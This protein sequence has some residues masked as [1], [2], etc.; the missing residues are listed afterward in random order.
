MLHLVTP[1]DVLFSFNNPT[2]CP[3]QSLQLTLSPSHTHARTHTKQQTE[4]IN[5]KV[6]DTAT[7]PSAVTAVPVTLPT[8]TV[9][10]VYTITL[11]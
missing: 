11:F 2:G 9:S 6:Q 4:H 7:R 1:A 10:T 8:K 5:L 3:L